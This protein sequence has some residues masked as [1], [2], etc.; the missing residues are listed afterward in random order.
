MA[1]KK[2]VVQLSAEERNYLRHFVSTG[3]HS[4][5]EF[6][7]AQILLLTDGGRTDKDIYDLLDVS[8]RTIERIRSRYV[9][10][11]LDLAIWDMPRSGQPKKLSATQEAQIIAIACSDAPAG[12]NHWTM[13]L[14]RNEAIDRGVVDKISTEPIRILLKMHGLKPWRKKNVV[15]SRAN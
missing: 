1:Y 7:R 11:G 14:L 12:G 2:Y 9:T 15:Y 4:A 13:E 6:L 5:R 10:G 3:K 8:T